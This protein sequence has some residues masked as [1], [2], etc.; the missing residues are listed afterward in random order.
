MGPSNKALAP[1]ES[2]VLTCPFTGE[3][4]VID[5]IPCGIN[6]VVMYRARGPFYDT[7]LYGEKQALYYDLSTRGGV[8]PSF[9][10]VLRKV[11]GVRLIERP[12]PSSPVDS[13]REINTDFIG[14]VL[15]GKLKIPR[16]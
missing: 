9:S 16:R 7:K 2:P 3:E 13:N 8:R 1:A 11:Q 12:N 15:K 5:E 10:R 4:L 14:D 6:G